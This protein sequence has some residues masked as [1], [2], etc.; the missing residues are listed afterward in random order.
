MLRS[1]PA[2]STLIQLTL[3]SGRW[4]R[5]DETNAV[6]LNH[7]AKAFFPKLKVGDQVE[8][9]L[10][11]RLASFTLV[12][13]ARELVSPSSAYVLPETFNR[14]MGNEERTNAMRIVLEN[15]DPTSVTRIS[16]RVERALE[17]AGIGVSINVSE[18]KLDSALNGHVYILIFA[19]I[20]MAVLMALVGALGLTSAMST[21]VIERTREFGIMRTIGA[22]GGAVLRNVIGEGLLIGLL[23]WLIAL[24]LSLPLSYGIGNLVGTLAFR[25]PLALTVSPAAL[26][27][28]FGVVVIGSVAASAYPAWT[29]SR[30]TIRETLAYL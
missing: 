17:N 12:G 7:S 15:H 16:G 29:A 3:V 11:G 22:Q 8:L 5:P 23:S 30:L 24:P 14:I 10:G 25:F 9:S 1:T 20:S 21:S 2:N 4:L 27:L 19:L 26:L 13:V 6:V 28:W 18:T